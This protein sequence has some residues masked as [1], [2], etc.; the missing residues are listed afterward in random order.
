M[1]Y[2][3]AKISI[4]W[5]FTRDINFLLEIKSKSFKRL[6]KFVSAVLLSSLNFSKWMF[7]QKQQ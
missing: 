6:R 4:W 5:Y 3:Q 2:E 7:K 1:S